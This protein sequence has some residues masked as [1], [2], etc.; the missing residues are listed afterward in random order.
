MK[1]IPIALQSHL[2]QDATTWCRLMRVACKDGTVIGFTDL[3]ADVTYDDGNGAVTYRA[4]MGAELSRYQGTAD[5]SVDNAEVMGWVSP[6]GITEAQIR[7]GLLD[8]ARVRIY[9]V[10]YMDLTQ[11]HEILASGTAG[12]TG[13]TQNS[14]RAE[15]RSLTQQLRQP[16]S[17]VDSLTCRAR[18][19]SK[20]LGTVTEQPTERF[21][22]NKDWVWVAGT[23][24]SIG[25]DPRRLFTDSALAQPADHFEFGVVEWLTGQNAGAQ[26]EVDAFAFGGGIT[27]ALP[28]AYPIVA[29]DTFRIRQD[30]SKEFAYCRDVHNNVLNNRSEHL[31]PVADGGANL[32]PGAQIS[33]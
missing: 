3:D 13:F 27:L 10:N 12:E 18:F 22:C 11:G 25:S 1:S 7:S 32:I 20:P 31:I 5:L 17:N 33:R 28:L 23:V 26:M 19:G 24:T 29:G 6:D 21:P 2:D 16:I 9:R 8:Y 14:F 30:C 4:D 15:F